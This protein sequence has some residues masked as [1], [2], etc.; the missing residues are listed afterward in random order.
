MLRHGGHWT[1]W[2]VQHKLWAPSICPRPG[3]VLAMRGS[4]CSRERASPPPGGVLGLPWQ[5]PEWGRRDCCKPPGYCPD[6]SWPAGSTEQEQQLSA[7]LTV[8]SGAYLERGITG[9]LGL[10]WKWGAHPEGGVE[11]DI[12]GPAHL[13]ILLLSTVQSSHP[14]GGGPVWEWGG[15]GRYQRISMLPQPPQGALALRLVSGQ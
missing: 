14:D 2:A 1:Y 12:V 13:V 9:R 11:V 8:C 10:T 5:S 6:S 4:H 3:H 15:R 7:P